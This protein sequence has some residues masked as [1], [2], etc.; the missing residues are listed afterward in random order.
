MG[1]WQITLILLASIAA[2]AAIGG[3]LSYL[4]LRFISRKREITFLSHLTSQTTRKPEAATVF[5]K[6]PEIQY[7]RKPEAPRVF[8]EQVAQAEQVEKVEQERQVKPAVPTSLTRELIAEVKQN[9]SISAEPM[10]DRLLPFQTSVWDAHQYK[11][12]KLPPD[13]RDDLEQAY[14]DMRLANSLVWLSSS[15][16]VGHGCAYRRGQAA[17]RLRGFAVHRCLWRVELLA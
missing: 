11:V 7:S 3:L 13:L 12:D 9:R 15:R 10:G 14:T 8:T 16:H 17:G 6:Q 5:A 2:G 4:I 1:W